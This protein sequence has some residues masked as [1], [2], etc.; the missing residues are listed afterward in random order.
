MVSPEEMKDIRDMIVEDYGEGDVT[1]ESLIDSEIIASAEIMTNEDG[2]VS[3]TPETMAVFNE[4]ELECVCKVSD[5]DKIWAGQELMKIEGPLKDI[6]ASERVALNLLSRMSGVATATMEM[7]ERAKKVNEDVKIAATRKT[8]PLHRYFDKRAVESV[9]GEPHR[10]HLGDFVLIKD[11]HLRFV[12]S[13]KE[14]VKKARRAGLSNKIE[15]EVTNSGEAEEAVRA[16]ADIV[17]LDNFSPE[18]VKEAVE[19]LKEKGIREDVVIES[20]GGIDPSNVGKYAAAGVDV[21]SSSYMTMKAPALDIK[22]D[23]VEE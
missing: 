7:I 16:G 14:A 12:G 20:S 10:Y 4:F 11:N 8:I 23:V 9:G 19:S 6:L 22:L 21:I 18:E 5:G 17:M 13:V 2:Y 1:T 3:G 15:V